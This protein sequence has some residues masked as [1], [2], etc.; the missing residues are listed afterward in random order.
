MIAKSAPKTAKAPK[1]PKVEAKAPA[2]PKAPT[3]KNAMVAGLLARDEGATVAQIAEVTGWKTS[4]A[5]SSIA[6]LLVAGIKVTST[7]D[8]G[9]ERVYRIVA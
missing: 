5:R 6:H 9:C 8:K 4:A 1:T 7:K 2:S 3:G